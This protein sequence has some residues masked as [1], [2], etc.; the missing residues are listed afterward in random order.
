MERFLGALSITLLLSGLAAVTQLQ[1]PSDPLEQIVQAGLMTPQPDSS[2]NIMLSRA[3]LASILVKVFHL[4]RQSSGLPKTLVQLGDVPTSHW[5]YQ[6]VQLVLKNGI[7]NGYREGRF[8]PDQ[9]IT[10]A[11]AFAIFAQAFGV[12]QFPEPT[13]TQVL[14]QYPDAAQIPHWARKPMATAL[15]EGFVNTK[16]DRIDPL[17]PMTRSDIAYALTVYLQRQDAR[18]Q[19]KSVLAQLVTT[20][21]SATAEPTMAQSAQ[22]QQILPLSLPG[23]HKS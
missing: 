17:S 16:G 11:E 20:V 18:V 22:C 6:D 23:R 10:R 3:E 5:A 15:Q 21:A 7:M 1:A 14:A 13:V 2:S 4:D 12:F 19:D 8:Y 9:R